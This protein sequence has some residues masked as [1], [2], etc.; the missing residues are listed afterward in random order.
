MGEDVQ[1][2][3]R[4]PRALRRFSAKALTTLS[5]FSPVWGHISAASQ[6]ASSS[7]QEVPCPR[8]ET[9]PVVT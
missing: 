4:Q 3:T 2:C 1:R 8:P 9:T 7:S 5:R 6:T